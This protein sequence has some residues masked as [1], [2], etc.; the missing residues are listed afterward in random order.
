MIKDAYNLLV[1]DGGD[2][3]P[4]IRDLKV[5]F[6]GLNNVWQPWMSIHHKA[7]NLEDSITDEDIKEA[8]IESQEMILSVSNEQ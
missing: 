6:F 1:G 5:L 8:Q 7:N 2:Y 4:V 3:T